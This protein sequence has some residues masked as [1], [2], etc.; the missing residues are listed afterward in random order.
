MYIL[1]GALAPLNN[2]RQFVLVELSPGVPKIAKHAI[3]PVNFWHHNPHDPAIWMTCAEASHL[4]ATTPVSPGK[5]GWCVGFVITENDPF[6]CLDLD[7]C[8]TLEGGWNDDAQELMRRFPGAVELSI[9]GRGLHVW[10]QYSGVLPDH[11]SNP[12]GVTRELYSK[13]R[14]IC[15]GTVA[16]GIM[17]DLS[18]ILP[19]F[20][21]DYFPPS[22]IDT[23]TAAWTTEPV[24][25]W[26]A[27][28]DEQIIDKARHR[29]RPQSAGVL[30]GSASKLPDFGDL[31][32]ANVSVLA[33]AFP[34]D[35]PNKQYG[36]S[37][38]DM[39]L[40]KELAYW[41]G[42]NCEAIERIMQGSALR[43]DKWDE[44][45][46]DTTYLRRTILMAV[47]YCTAVYHLPPVV[48]PPA[49]PQSKKL[50]PQVIDQ[51]TRIVFRESMA[52]MFADCVY[53]QDNNGVLLANGDIVDQARFN[54][55]FAGFN[56]GMDIG[57]T[58][59]SKTAW[60]AFLANQVIEFPRCDGTEFNP[61]LEFQDV[62]ERGGR[63]WINT[64]KKPIV[65]SEP[66][67]TSRFMGLLRKLLPN[68][69]D[70]II[71]LSYMA[72]CVQYPGVKF[73]WAPFI[74]GA[75]GN[76]KST[77]VECLKYA[78]GFKYIFSVKAGMIENNFNAWLESNVLYVADDIYSSRDRTDMME[79]LK[80]LITERDHGI[81]LKGIDSIQKRICGNFIFTD[82]HKDAMK[83]QDDTRRIC[84]LYC[85]QQ[86][87][88][89]RARDGLAKQFFAGENGF[90]AWL[91][92]GGFKH[93]AHMLQTMPID[94]RY[95]PAGE[96]Q[97]APDT[98]VTREAVIDGRTNL[99]HD[100]A[101]W[102][103]LDEPGFAGGFVSAH[104][105]RARMEAI[106]RYAKFFSPLKVKET[107]Q[108][109]G[110]ETHRKLIDGRLP[111]YVA[112]DNTKPIIYVKADT[113]QA[114]LVDPHAV[115]SLYAAAQAEAAANQTKRMMGHG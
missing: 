76:G 14:F 41:T 107:M 24:P 9:S 45:R 89:D 23:D 77:L 13:S 17:H 109:L 108:R 49:P 57:N 104:M 62:I 74:Q 4:A 114:E 70:A 110:Y 106:P 113:W 112:P 78:L 35:D 94:A 98:S 19:Q 12:K 99:E 58:K 10:A 48:L 86:S 30:M 69:D 40:A 29:A 22:V 105:L 26:T 95:N 96:C 43:R 66:G 36:G 1:P 101:E 73:R 15:L 51:K 44:R 97:E 20:I 42:K 59:Y 6:I 8:S 72:A 82:N 64:Y 93:V 85:A 34:S 18:A 60:E 5:L 50:V 68:G 39:A 111:I 7:N 88:A 25:E 3:N 56:L 47:A 81:T 11:G 90:I 28:T 21:A 92:S 84:T 54:A 91:N 65:E 33:G 61:Q 46:R 32:D 27:L 79:S 52:Q 100:I 102:I 67:D 115:A 53:I 38:A 2:H 75:M 37:D 63:T 71:L 83:K 16:N 31:Y 87:K 80:S 103:E 55:K